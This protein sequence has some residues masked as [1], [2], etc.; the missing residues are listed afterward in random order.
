ME[1]KVYNTVTDTFAQYYS[2]FYCGMLIM[3]VRRWWVKNINIYKIYTAQ[4]CFT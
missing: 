3:C 1:L 2:F 4:Y